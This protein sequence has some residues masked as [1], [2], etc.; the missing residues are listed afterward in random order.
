MKWLDVGK[1]YA[2]KGQL[3]DDRV[4]ERERETRQK[5]LKYECQKMMLK[6]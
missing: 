5:L 3:G 6:N 1:G 4:S 2:S